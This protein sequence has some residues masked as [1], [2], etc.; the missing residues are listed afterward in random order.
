[1][2]VSE[3][4]HNARSPLEQ[5]AQLIQQPS[6][7][8]SSKDVP[9]TGQPVWEIG[10]V[11]EQQQASAA[12]AFPSIPIEEEDEDPEKGRDGGEEEVMAVTMTAS[13]ADKME[14]TVKDS[15]LSQSLSRSVPAQPELLVPPP[16][17]EQSE[18]F[19]HQTLQTVVTGCDIPEQ[20]ATLEGSQVDLAEMLIH[21]KR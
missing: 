12:A 11:M 3:T 2:D 14:K 20:R 16:I 18:L 5:A 7:E 1:M 15:M 9:L 6:I 8:A 13:L 21:T 19:D 10:M 4:R 17:H